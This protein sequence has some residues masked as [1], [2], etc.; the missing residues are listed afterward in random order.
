MGLQNPLHHFHNK[1]IV[2]VHFS[3]IPKDPAE[4]V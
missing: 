3:F 1:L 2:L 4:L